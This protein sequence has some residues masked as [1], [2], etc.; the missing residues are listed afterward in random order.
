MDKPPERITQPQTISSSW[1]GNL[2]RA[3]TTSRRRSS[4]LN[5]YYCLPEDDL[6]RSSIKTQPDDNSDLRPDIRRSSIKT[7]PDD[8]S[9]D[10]AGAICNGSIVSRATLDTIPSVPTPQEEGES[11]VRPL[12]PAPLSDNEA[13]PSLTSEEDI[14]EPLLP[15]PPEVTDIATTT[16]PTTVSSTNPP[17]QRPPPPPPA[18]NPYI[19]ANIGALVPT[20]RRV[21]KVIRIKKK[22]ATTI[23]P[24]PPLKPHVPLLRSKSTPAARDLWAIPAGERDEQFRDMVDG[25]IERILSHKD[26][27]AAQEDNPPPSP[28]LYRVTATHTCRLPDYK[29]FLDSK[30]LRKN[31]PLPYA[32]AV[33]KAAW[34]GHHKWSQLAHSSPIRTSVAPKRTRPES[35]AM[36]QQMRTSV[37]SMP[38]PRHMYDSA[39]SD[40]NQPWRQI[41]GRQRPPPRSPGETAN[42]GGDN[43]SSS[44]GSGG[45]DDGKKKVTTED[46]NAFMER[47]AKQR[48]EK[49]DKIMQMRKEVWSQVGMRQRPYVNVQSV[50]LLQKREKRLQEAIESGEAVLK[51][52]EER[53]WRLME[54]LRE[55]RSHCR[56]HPIISESTEAILLAAKK[57]REAYEN[58][59]KRDVTSPKHGRK[60]SGSAGE[61]GGL[62]NILNQNHTD[63]TFKPRVNE[64]SDAILQRS[65]SCPKAFQARLDLSV[66]KYYMRRGGNNNNNNNHNGLVMTGVEDEE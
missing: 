40:S 37:L 5:Y 23:S 34:K 65:K 11:S 9:A 17:P 63:F 24:P 10:G 14:V 12:P 16:S 19:Q 38:L 21:R 31:T 54:A 62:L 6:R 56:F 44:S 8:D 7:Q 33:I 47:I 66:M 18:K 57:R 4:S 29:Y 41:K 64:S 55:E 20:T 25:H 32:P 39:A 42:D 59:F 15:T 45:G 36:D 53:D 51:T 50:W 28:P 35:F 2:R 1:S 27:A 60:G 46:V 61:E 22:S 49:R 13:P 3:S 52:K 30:L 58:T 48:H 26:K 43:S